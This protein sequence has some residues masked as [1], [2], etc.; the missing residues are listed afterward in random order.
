MKIALEYCGH[1]RFIQ[2]TFPRLKE[3]FF[4]KEKI[5]FYVF[6]HTWDCSRQNDIEYMKN[7]IKPH[8]YY[9]DTQKNFERHPY[10]L[11]NVDLT[12]DEYKNDPMRLKWNQEHHEDIKAFF[13]KPSPDNNYHFDKDL[14]VV[15][16]DYY[17]AFPYTQL[18]VF[19]SM[20]Q[21]SLLRKSYAQEF[22]IE[23]DY[24]MRIRSDMHFTEG[25]NLDNIDSKKLNAFEAPNH[26]GPQGQYTI[27]DQFG[28]AKPEIMN[29]YDDFFIYYPCYYMI[30]KLDWVSEIMM[31][32]HLSYNNIQVNKLPRYFMLLRYPD[33]SL[34]TRP[35]Q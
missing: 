33:R 6:I 22:G 19:Y 25:I 13:E 28:I 23:F 16:F 18:S 2:E 10:Q 35:V 8:R 15:K 31:G 30:F 32:F 11:I 26:K 24:V 27:Q 20:H 4:S 5:E 7:I 34:Y 12:H 17:S 29:I 21:V 1:L 3:Y 14:Q 9:V